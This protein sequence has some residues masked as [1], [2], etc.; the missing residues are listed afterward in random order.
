VWRAEITDQLQLY[1]YYVDHPDVI[2]V[3]QR[4][5]NAEAPAAQRE[6][7]KIPG[8]QLVSKEIAA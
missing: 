2:A 3:L 5:A 4:L 6:G 1:L 8:A 7:R